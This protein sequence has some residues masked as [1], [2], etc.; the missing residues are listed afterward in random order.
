MTKQ[1]YIEHGFKISNFIE[2]AE[3]E[4]AERDVIAAYNI[5]PIIGENNDIS[6]KIRN[7]AIGNLAYLLLM[8]RSTFLTRAGAKTKTGYNS[9]D[10]DAWAKLQD[11]A[12]SCHLAL[13]QLKS[14]IPNYTES[15]VIDICKIYFKTNFI[16]Q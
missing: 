3:I 6:E 9:A 1:W 13:E 15:R 2:D 16:S 14:V 11:A 10:V 12:N 7:N 8:Q 5:T 4:R